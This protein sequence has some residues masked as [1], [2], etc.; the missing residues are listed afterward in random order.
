[1]KDKQ[2]AKKK[3]QREEIAKKRVTARRKRSDEVK[4]KDNEQFRL[5]RKYRDKI[6]PYRKNQVTAEQ[7][8]SGE[9]S[10]SQAKRTA[11]SLVEPSPLDIKK[12]S[13][14][15]IKDKMIIERLKKNY[16][17]LKALEEEYF[18][19]KENREELNAK[20]ESQQA[21]TL[22]EKMDLMNEKVR[23]QIGDNHL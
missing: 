9:C 19:E 12:T 17:V 10:V 21:V 13:G 1:M 15:P 16:E 22:K 11:E 5:E 14:N 23:E 6:P 8:F 7:L 4:K 18:K 2:R 3:K 20:L